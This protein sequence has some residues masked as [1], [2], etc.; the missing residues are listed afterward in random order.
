MCLFYTV[1]VC[2]T[3]SE[4][5][6]LTSRVSW[7][8]EQVWATKD[9]AE[10]RLE[11]CPWQ[12]WPQNQ[13]SKLFCLQIMLTQTSPQQ[14]EQLI[15]QCFPFKVQK[16]KPLWVPCPCSLSKNL[17]L[18]LCNK[19]NKTLRWKP[20]STATDRLWTLRQQIV[21]SPH[22]ACHICEGEAIKFEK[23]CVFT[24]SCIFLSSSCSVAMLFNES[25]V[26]FRVNV[27]RNV[28]S[29]F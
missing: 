18:G 21:T 3:W 8:P 22:R 26:K 15:F 23:G 7:I 28:D 9:Q 20:L 13:S 11:R 19:M 2:I 1:Y 12:F 6:N 14:L 17:K 25:L 27:D 4:S 24:K 5:W 29:I 10:V 16:L